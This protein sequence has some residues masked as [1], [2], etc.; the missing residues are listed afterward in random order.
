ME[1]QYHGNDNLIQHSTLVKVIPSSGAVSLCS[2]SVKP[3]VL[4]KQA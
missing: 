3:G 1:L 2:W 4:Q